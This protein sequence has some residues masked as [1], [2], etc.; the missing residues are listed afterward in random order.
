MLKY[1][2][3][4]HTSLKYASA[5]ASGDEAELPGPGDGLGAVGRAELAEKMADMLLHGVEGDDELTGM[6]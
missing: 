4:K 3:L 6:A 2:L 5:G 1:I